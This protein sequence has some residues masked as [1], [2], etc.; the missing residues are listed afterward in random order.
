[1]AEIDH[2]FTALLPS[3]S[4]MTIDPTNKPSDFIVRFSEPI[5]LSHNYDWE[6]ALLEMQYPFNWFNVAKPITLYFVK[7][8]ELER[9][10]P[11]DDDPAY[12]LLH[13][14]GLY[15]PQEQAD[16]GMRK[17]FLRTFCQSVLSY[18]N[19]RDTEYTM[20]CG[21]GN[22]E[23]QFRVFKRIL[24]PALYT[25]VQKLLDKICDIANSLEGLKVILKA[26]FDK[27]SGCCI[28]LPFSE[29]T[30]FAMFSD[31][32]YFGELLGLQNRWAALLGPPYL[33]LYV[34]PWA[35]QKRFKLPLT[36]SLFVYAEGSLIDYQIVGDVKAPL[37]GIVP[38]NSADHGRHCSWVFNPPTYMRVL[39]SQISDAHIVIRAENGEDVPFLADSSPV[40]CRLHFRHRD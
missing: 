5:R 24:E 27:A 12:A 37:L 16:T 28:F 21:E 14:L 7:M 29:K 36:N 10:P 22:Q 35:G 18:M 13:S 38:V 32:H 15:L 8:M 26:Q 2:P 4:N 30:G 3:N 19:E 23:M 17:K 6:V 31:S 25:S 33:P 20:A 9:M 11:L 40:V 39:S 34:H 1:M